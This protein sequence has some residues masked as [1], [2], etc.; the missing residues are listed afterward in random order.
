MADLGYQ[1]ITFAE[2]FHPFHG[3]SSVQMT[4]I[5]FFKQ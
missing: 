5:E 4:N 3:S 1:A 2:K